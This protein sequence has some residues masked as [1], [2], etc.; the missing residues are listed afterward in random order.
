MLSRGRLLAARLQQR[1]APSFR[2]PE[3][4]RG[5]LRRVPARQ[6]A[7]HAHGREL[8]S[9][10]P[11][12]TFALKLVAS[13]LAGAALTLLLWNDDPRTAVP[14]PPDTDLVAAL[15]PVVREESVVYS[16]NRAAGNVAQWHAAESELDREI[17]SNF[18]LRIRT[19]KFTVPGYLSS[20]WSGS[21]ALSGKR[22]RY[23]IGTE[24]AGLGSD[25]EV[26]EVSYNTTRPAKHGISIAYCNLFDEK[27]TGR[28]GPYLHTSDTAQQYNEGQIDPRG[29]G[30]EKNLREQ[31]ERRRRQG[32]EYI[33]L[34]NPDAY[35]IKDVIGA[36]DLAAGYGLKVIAK[37]PALMAAGSAA[38]NAYVAHPN[39]YGII[40]EKGAGNPGGM[41]ALRRRAGKPNLPV[42]FVAFG[43]GRSWAG[44]V[45]DAAKHYRNMGVTYSSAGEYGNAIDILPPA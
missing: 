42:W 19:V 12:A 38:A 43:S 8:S 21:N 23:L 3:P 32:F 31:Y 1:A 4:L 16:R 11:A 14:Y 15:Y 28:Y 29:P 37:N 9:I 7:G 34:D 39:V 40:V 30:W 6:R 26:V 2:R 36:I 45:A 17:P 27:N 13:G 5:E 18:P 41:D 35:S 22:L 24:G 33:E 25:E 10:L 44:S 20:S